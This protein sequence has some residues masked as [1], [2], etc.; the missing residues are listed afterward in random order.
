M[1]LT[2]LFFLLSIQIS[3]QTLKFIPDLNL[4]NEL[5][6]KG[7]ITND[8]LDL[9]KTKGV[10][11]LE[12]VNSGIENL[13]GLQYFDQVFELTISKTKISRLNYLPP[14]LIFLSCMDNNISQIDSLPSKITFID[15]QNNNITSIGKLPDQLKYLV[16]N[17]NK[18]SVIHNFPDGLQELNLSNNQMTCIPRLPN[19]ILSFNY[20]HNPIP[21]DSLPQFYKSI[22]CNDPWQ[23]C[24]PYELRKLKILQA[25][26]KNP[27]RK[28][29]GMEIK[30]YH[31]D[32][33]FWTQ[34]E[35]LNFRLIKSKLVADT[36]ITRTRNIKAEEVYTK[37]KAYTLLEKGTTDSTDFFKIK[38]SVD[39]NQL[40]KIVND[41]YLNKIP[42]QMLVGHSI[43]EFDLKKNKKQIY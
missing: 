40:E 5:N 25:T 22:D 32:M 18:I 35:T 3:A 2:I 36:I 7:F 39:I 10:L 43:N 19:S 37:E 6:K 26:I 21:F 20:A 28:I 33:R 34:T 9:R 15:C 41:I 4:K 23:N 30:L 38:T 11:Q 14:N 17:N 31:R 1:K 16:C 27:T 24:L 12:F 29:I 13:D 8:S 42:N